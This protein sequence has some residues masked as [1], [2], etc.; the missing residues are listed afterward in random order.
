MHITSRL[1]VL[2]V[3]TFRS[4]FAMNII[5]QICV[6]MCALLF[7]HAAFF[8]FTSDEDYE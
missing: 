8:F 3:F 4:L 7:M 2:T 6:T 1:L 5:S